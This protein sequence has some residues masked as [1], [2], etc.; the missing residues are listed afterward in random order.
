MVG[1]GSLKPSEL[2]G[3]GYP[4]GQGSPSRS[5]DPIEPTFSLLRSPESQH[6]SDKL[7]QACSSPLTSTPS[8]TLP[9]C[10]SRTRRCR[11]S[12]MDQIKIGIG[13]VGSRH[14]DITTRLA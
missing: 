6:R 10:I 14:S 7:A 5:A 2:L 4:A 1:L 8:P 9:T 12:V 13:L 11:L 3:A